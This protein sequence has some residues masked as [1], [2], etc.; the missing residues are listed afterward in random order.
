MDTV[1]PFDHPEIRAQRKPGEV[2]PDKPTEVVHYTSQPTPAKKSELDATTQHTTDE[3]LK[4]IAVDLKEGR[5][6]TDRH[7]QKEDGRM[8][9]MVFMPIALGA[10]ENVSKED[11]ENIGLIYEHLS[12]A[13]PRSCNGYPGSFSMHLLNR[14]DTARMFE[15]YDKLVEAEKT[16]LETK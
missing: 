5:I 3:D 15:W 10:F 6:F 11:L 16:V 13:G 14:D 12:E 1:P 9:S 7:I 8:L 4:K 2:A